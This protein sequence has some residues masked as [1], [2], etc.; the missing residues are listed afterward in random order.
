[1]IHVMILTTIT[2]YTD[3]SCLRLIFM[4]ELTSPTLTEKDAGPTNPKKHTRR[5]TRPTLNVRDMQDSQVQ[6]I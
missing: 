6:H 4:V 5:H 3:K 1:M 2:V